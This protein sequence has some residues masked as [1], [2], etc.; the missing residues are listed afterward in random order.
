MLLSSAIIETS[1]YGKDF[2]T[3][4]LIIVL[5]TLV[6]RLHIVVSLTCTANLYSTKNKL[7]VKQW[8]KFLKAVFYLAAFL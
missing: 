2:F 4:V 3:H 8:H 6:S 1:I 7:F 5:Q